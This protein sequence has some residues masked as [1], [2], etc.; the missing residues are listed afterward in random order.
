MYRKKNINK[1]KR[2]GKATD[3]KKYINLVIKYALNSELSLYI[4]WDKKKD[5]GNEENQMNN[6]NNNDINNEYGDGRD[7]NDGI[8]CRIK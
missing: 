6:D 2:D 1:E 7:G 4:K 5:L 3:D 8:I